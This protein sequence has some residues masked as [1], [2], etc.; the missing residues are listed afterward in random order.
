MLAPLL[1]LPSVT[2]SSFT[3][4]YL[5]QLHDEYKRLRGFHQLIELWE[6][7]GVIVE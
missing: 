1:S 4:L 7:G 2:F 3:V 6:S 5:H